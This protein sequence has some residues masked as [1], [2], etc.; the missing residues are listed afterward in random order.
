M[1]MTAFDNNARRGPF[2]LILFRRVKHKGEGGTRVSAGSTHST[3]F[4]LVDDGAVLLL[5]AA[6]AAGRDICFIERRRGRFHPG[7][8]VAAG[9]DK[10]EE[11]ERGW[12]SY[13]VV[14]SSVRTAQE[15]KVD[16][17]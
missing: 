11:E 1:M 12:P 14:I 13:L 2:F 17:I 9:H 5:D 3:R 7:R 4:P 10:K 16:P 6:A 15:R 8:C